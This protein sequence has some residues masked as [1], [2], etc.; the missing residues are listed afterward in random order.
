MKISKLNCRIEN[1]K[2]RTVEMKKS[3]KNAEQK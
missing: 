3:I 1:M 2:N